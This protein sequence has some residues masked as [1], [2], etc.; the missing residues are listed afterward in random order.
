MAIFHILS[1]L[2]GFL[3]AC[4]GW[5]LHALEIFRNIFQAALQNTTVKS[6][7]Y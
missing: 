2:N 5:G 3:N 6:W 1:I 7:Q 4:D